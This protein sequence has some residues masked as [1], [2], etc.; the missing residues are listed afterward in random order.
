MSLVNLVF[1]LAISV[2][3]F[4][5]LDFSTFNS[6]G[7]L[8]CLHDEF[9]L[10]LFISFVYIFLRL[11]L[12]EVGRLINSQLDLRIQ[13]LGLVLITDQFF[14]CD[15]VQLRAKPRRRLSVIF[16]LGR[17]TPDAISLIVLSLWRFRRSVRVVPSIELLHIYHFR[18]IIEAT[19]LFCQNF[20]R[21][22]SEFNIVVITLFFTKS[23]TYS[24]FTPQS[25]IFYL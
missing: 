15:L 22:T 6:F 4:F 19:V 5:A 10:V 14:W 23:T 8:A 12:I 1:Q 13:V 24:M 17:L 11:K 3:Q 2:L 20:H 18:P 9:G 25:K 16:S 7:I 21:R